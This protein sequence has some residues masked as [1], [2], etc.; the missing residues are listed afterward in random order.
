MI[1]DGMRPD[2]VSPELIPRLAALAASGAS[3]DAHHAVLPTVTRV[4]AATL[5]TGAPTAVH[6]LPANV[7]YAPAVDARAAISIGDGDN[8]PQLSQAYG[9]FGATTISDVVRASG[10]RT[11]ILSSG[12]RGSA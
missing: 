7:F 4:N 6:G 9:V 11:V 5:A 10:G 8:V 1:W 12:T 2:L 3:F